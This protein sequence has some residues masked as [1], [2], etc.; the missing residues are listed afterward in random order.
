MAAAEQKRDELK[1]TFEKSDMITLHTIKETLKKGQLSLSN[2]VC[3]YIHSCLQSSSQSSATYQKI[4][5]DVIECREI[6]SH[7]EQASVNSTKLINKQIKELNAKE[8]A[9]EPDSHIA[10]LPNEE[11]LNTLSPLIPRQSNFNVRK[12]GSQRR[13]ILTFILSG[14]LTISFDNKVEQEYSIDDILYLVKGKKNKENILIRMVLRGREEKPEVYLFQDH[15]SRELFYEHY[16][17]AKRGLGKVFLSQNRKP[18]TH[19]ELTIWCGTWNM[20]DAQPDYKDTEALESWMPKEKYDMYVISTQESEYTPRPGYI[21]PEEDLWSLLRNHLGDNY[22]KLANVSLQHIRI[23]CF[24]RR[25]H[26]Y[27]ICHVK[28]GTVATGLAGVIGN[29]G[30]CGIAFDIYD[31]RICFIGSHLAARIDK[32]RLEARNQNYRDIL[33]GLASGFSKNGLND[34]HHEFDH[35]IWLGDLNYRIELN[36]SDIINKIRLGDLDSLR[37]ADQLLDGM[38]S[39]TCFLDFEEMEIHYSP[40]YRYNRG[41]RTFSEEKMREPAWCDRVLYKTIK[42]EYIKPLNYSACHSLVTSD[43]SPVSG[44]FSVFLN[45]PSMPHIRDANCKISISNLKAFDLKAIKSGYYLVF[46]APFMSNYETSVSDKL[47]N[48]VWNDKLAL[49]PAVTNKSYFAHRWIRV[50]IKDSKDSCYGQGIIY[51]EH[52]LESMVDFKTRIVDKGR[53]VGHVEGKIGIEFS[54]GYTDPYEY[55]PV[56]NVLKSSMY[57]KEDMST[58]LPSFAIISKQAEH[59]QLDGIQDEVSKITVGSPYSHSPVSSPPSDSPL[60][61][62][63]TWSTTKPTKLN[64]LTEDIQIYNLKESTDSLADTETVLIE[65]TCTMEEIKASQHKYI[66]DSKLDDSIDLARS[67]PES[68]WEMNTSM[69]DTEKKELRLSLKLPHQNIMKKSKHTS[70]VITGTKTKDK[71]FPLPPQKKQEAPTQSFIKARPTPNVSNLRDEN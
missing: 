31:N 66:D 62:K 39:E 49:Y 43:H 68:R 38:K 25:N 35:V 52:A 65:E 44:S 56:P 42:K 54:E 19:E 23:A 24:V 26:Y 34:I 9:V 61:F 8:D 29:K 57:A 27:K 59:I 7:E 16:W 1:T 11:A 50:V 45:L 36:R 14:T 63:S 47:T 28:V 37:N 20:G 67:L 13:Y 40:T 22:M 21:T 18:I 64:N 6:I 41:D 15:T 51:L 2:R 60:P 17:L 46:Q 30:G 69:V 5:Q 70:L 32:K 58:S 55:E 3:D 4:Q 71:P 33:K 53:V 12:E 48:P 10:F